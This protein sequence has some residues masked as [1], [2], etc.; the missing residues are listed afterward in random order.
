MAQYWISVPF[1]LSLKFKVDRVKTEEQA[2]RWQ[3]DFTRALSDVEA[4][5]FPQLQ[6]LGVVGVASP[7]SIHLWP[8]EIQL[9]FGSFKA[10]ADA[11]AAI[12]STNGMVRDIIRVIRLLHPGNIQSGTIDLWKPVT[13]T[14]STTTSPKVFDEPFETTEFRDHV[15]EV[16]TSTAAS[17]MSGGPP[18]SYPPV[19]TT[20]N[21]APSIEPRR[22]MKQL[23]AVLLG[24]AYPI[25]IIVAVALYWMNGAEQLRVQ[26]D[27]QRNLQALNT[28]L[29]KHVQDALT[30]RPAEGQ[31][32]VEPPTRL[33]IVVR[34]RAT[35]VVDA[36]QRRAFERSS[37]STS[38]G[39]HHQSKFRW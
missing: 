26:Q 37:A 2:A 34:V 29:E 10:A 1:R 20:P 17:P 28:A 5:R 36:E 32:V 18:S 21:S 23:G 22:F 39:D 33:E 15:P 8:A 24:I 3:T 25:F 35:A 12:Q 14:E 13:R 11:A 6:S 9:M 16:E 30:L 31:P 38:L 4:S 7:G 27:I 19:V